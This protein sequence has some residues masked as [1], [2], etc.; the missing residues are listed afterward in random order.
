MKINRM[1]AHLAFLPVLSLVIFC[2]SCLPKSKRI[3]PTDMKTIEHFT[4]MY[5]KNA[6]E[7]K[8]GQPDKLRLARIARKVV[9]DMG[10]GYDET[11][12]RFII[13]DRLKESASIIEAWAV[14]TWPRVDLEMALVDGLISQEAC[15]IAR[16]KK[17]VEGL[18]ERNISFV[19]ALLELAEKS[20]SNVVAFDDLKPYI[21]EKGIKEMDA[22]FVLLDGLEE[23]KLLAITKKVRFVLPTPSVAGKRPQ[24]GRMTIK[25]Q[26][27]F[28]I[29][30]RQGLK[31]IVSDYEQLEKLSPI[32]KSSSW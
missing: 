13:D 6:Q 18:N 9:E 26:T 12:T 30:D 11:F 5:K 3:M 32:S 28:Q 10:Y 19:R 25:Q 21:K 1:N 22:K 16:R 27:E 8:K 20:N 14:I 24:Q 31:E 7:M 23:R 29:L 15:D 2:T 17:R 4:E